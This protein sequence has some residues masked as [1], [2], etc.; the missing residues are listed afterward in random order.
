MVRD[1]MGITPR[2]DRPD[3]EHPRRPVEG[4]DCA[5]SEVSGSRFW[6]L[7]RDRFG[8][9][10]RFFAQQAVLPYCP[11]M[12]MKDSG[13]NL[14]PNGLRVAERRPMEEICD[15]YLDEVLTYFRPRRLVAIGVYAEAAFRRVR[16]EAEVVRIL[17][18]SP[19]SPAANRDWA[20]LVSA[21]LLDAGIWS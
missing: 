4:L 14:P 21:A 16:P 1:W 12:W 2:V 18:P 20:G 19:A 17:H 9:A 13:A 8:T 5:R 11:L 10:D 6:G 3:P 15:R 7:M